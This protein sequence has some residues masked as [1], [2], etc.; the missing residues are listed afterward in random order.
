MAE[1]FRHA[2]ILKLAREQ[3]NVVVDDL[4][5]HFGVTLQTIR[6]D[7]TELCDAGRLTRVY[8]GAV[9]PSGVSNIGYEDRRVLNA[10]AK[11]LI[12]SRVAAEIP[13]AAS[14]FLNIGTTTEAVARALLNHRNLMVVTNNL[15]VANILAANESAEVIVAGGVLRRADAGLVGDV[16]LE[17]VRHFKVDIAVIG[18]SALDEDGDLLD[19]DFREVRVSQAI[20]RQARKT[21]LAADVSKFQRNAPVRIASLSEVDAFF[22]DSAPSA[23]VAAL[24]RE[25]GTRVVTADAAAAQPA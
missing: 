18:T 20:I 10:D 11:E 2:E 12:A 25:W 14:V 17:M 19:F 9:L 22:T 24:C 21:Y 7:L 4:A 13:E 1:N 6:R 16:T 23:P 3:G 5:A 8:G 15:N